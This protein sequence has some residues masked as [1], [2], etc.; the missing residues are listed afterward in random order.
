MN[1]KL[2]INSIFE[3]ISGEAGAIPQ[4]TWCTFIRL[5]G[6]NLK[7]N[8]CD[9]PLGQPDKNEGVEMSLDQIIRTCNNKHIIITGGEPLLQTN[10]YALF[11]ILTDL[12]YVVQ[13]ETNGSFNVEL[14]KYNKVHFVFDLKC[15]SSGMFG[16]MDYKIFLKAKYIK[17]VIAD[18]L[19]LNF[20]L[21][22]MKYLNRKDAKYIISPLNADGNKILS[23]QK[24]IQKEAPE[25]FDNI[26]FS[27][28]IHKIFN[29]L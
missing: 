5:Q 16:F 21:Y 9:T 3:S 18:E 26:I 10:V 19:D 7:C 12:D 25:L 22:R 4:G 1:E 13:V 28:Q 20:A 11:D 14:E 24:I 2:R 8:W 29:L 15:P 27:I 17:F 6:C 23:I